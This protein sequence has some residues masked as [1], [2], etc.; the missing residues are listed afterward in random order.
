MLAT[1]KLDNYS[2]LQA[3]KINDVISYRL[4]SSK[5]VSVHLPESQMAP[6]NPFSFRGIFSKG[7]GTFSY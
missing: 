3:D 7:S 6:K 4:L 2:L 1:I 5:L